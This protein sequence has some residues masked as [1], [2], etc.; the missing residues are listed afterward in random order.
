MFAFCSKYYLAASWENISCP[1]ARLRLVLKKNGDV[2]F[3]WNFRSPCN[4]NTHMRLKNGA[5]IKFNYGM[6]VRVNV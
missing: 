6:T 5:P 4:V 1:A 3:M 2:A